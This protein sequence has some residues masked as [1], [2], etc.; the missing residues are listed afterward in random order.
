MIAG[1]RLPANVAID[2]GGPQPRRYRRTE[3]QV[4]QSK[5]SIPRPAI[6]QIAPERKHRLI[7]MQ[8]AQR[9]GPSHLDK[10]RIGGERRRLQKRDIKERFT[11]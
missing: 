11:E 8:F 6:A 5:P 7:R 2:A 3:Q 10:L 1:I 4:I 9:I